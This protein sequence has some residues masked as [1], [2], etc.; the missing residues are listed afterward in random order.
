VRTLRLKCHRAVLLRLGLI[1]LTSEAA[2]D[3]ASGF[4]EGHADSVFGA[5]DHHGAGFDG[6]AG[7]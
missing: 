5:Q 4:G 7:D 2:F 1:F 6:L 3:W